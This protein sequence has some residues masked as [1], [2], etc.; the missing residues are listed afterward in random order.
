[1]PGTAIELRNRQN[2]GWAQRDPT[3]LLDITYPTADVQGALGA[4][5]T[6]AKGKPIVFLGQRGRGKS[7]IM[8]LLHHAFES[9][10]RVEQWARGWGSQPG[11]QSLK[12]SQTRNTARFGI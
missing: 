8:A 7:H 3:E 10:D 5:S 6:A 9:P 4:I 1:M 2:T 12:Q 11:F